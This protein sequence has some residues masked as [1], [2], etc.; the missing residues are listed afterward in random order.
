MMPFSRFWFAWK[1]VY[2]L[3]PLKPDLWTVCEDGLKAWRVP[4]VCSTKHSHFNPAQELQQ[5]YFRLAWLL[6]VWEHTLIFPWVTHLPWKAG[7]AR[8][9]S[10]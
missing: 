6:A 5:P 2:A 3:H 9:R 10:A 1:A 4:V 8:C 7:C